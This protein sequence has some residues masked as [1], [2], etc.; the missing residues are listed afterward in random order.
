MF[1]GF[2]FFLPLLDTYS[3]REDDMQLI[4]RAGSEPGPGQ[5]VPPFSLCTFT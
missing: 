2:F 5:H 4:A 1:W 3:L